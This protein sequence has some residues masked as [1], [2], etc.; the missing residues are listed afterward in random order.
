MSRTKKIDTFNTSDKLI[1]ELTRSYTGKMLI[2]IHSTESGDAAISET[3]TTI[4][5]SATGALELYFWLQSLFQNQ[6]GKG[7]F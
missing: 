3:E 6:L 5:L 2:V 7:D 4:Q 1:C